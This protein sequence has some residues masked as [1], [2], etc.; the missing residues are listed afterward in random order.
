VYGL[1]LL[2]V[3]ELEKRGEVSGLP[4]FGTLFKKLLKL[5]NP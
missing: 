1:A 4:L 2:G 5:F 3:D